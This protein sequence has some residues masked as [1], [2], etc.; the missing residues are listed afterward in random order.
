MNFP[1]QT[2]IIL[3]YLISLVACMV[4][5]QLLPQLDFI[6]G[7]QEPENK[8][9]VTVFQFISDSISFV[10]FGIPMIERSEEHT[11]ELQSHSDLVCRLLLEKKQLRRSSAFLTTRYHAPGRG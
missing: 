5:A 9:T 11:S 1:S 10:S 3:I 7:W 6:A 4:A 8:I 2:K